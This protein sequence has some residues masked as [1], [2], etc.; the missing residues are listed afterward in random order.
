M[1]T[2]YITLKFDYEPEHCSSPQKWDWN[3]LI[4][5]GVH[6]EEI[7]VHDYYEESENPGSPD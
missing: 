7:S 2:A 5:I 1:K 6:N 4:G 3:E